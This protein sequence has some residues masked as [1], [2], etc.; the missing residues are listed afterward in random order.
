MEKQANY[1]NPEV[2]FIC[3]NG[4]NNNNPGKNSGTEYAMIK[5]VNQFGGVYVNQS[6]LV[7]QEGQFSFCLDF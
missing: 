5:S 6:W 4:Q 1:S 2:V 3:Q 7:S